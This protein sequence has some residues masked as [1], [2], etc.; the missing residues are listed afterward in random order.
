VRNKPIPEDH[1][2]LA[3]QGGGAKGVAYIGAYKAIKQNYPDLKIR[4]IIGSSA[5][6]MLAL[7]MS[8]GASVKELEALCEDMNQIPSDRLVKTVDDIPAIQARIN[9]DKLK[10]RNFLHSIGIVYN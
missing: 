9:E 10:I 6:G 7:A 8:A 4:S 1:F 3:F 2:N 5:G